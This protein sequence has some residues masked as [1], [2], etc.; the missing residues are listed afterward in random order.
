MNSRFLK[1]ITTASITC[2][3]SSCMTPQSNTNKNNNESQAKD[4][5]QLNGNDSSEYTFIQK[6]IIKKQ[7]IKKLPD[8]MLNLL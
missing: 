5:Q 7:T 1:L 3:L 4:E 6:I 8:F 2:I